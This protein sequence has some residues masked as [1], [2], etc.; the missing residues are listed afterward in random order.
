ML[1]L[2]PK[3]TLQPRASLF[4]LKPTS[5]GM[6][7]QSYTC[8]PLQIAPADPAGL[9]SRKQPCSDSNSLLTSLES[10]LPVQCK[11]CRQRVITQSLS[12]PAAPC[13][14][15]YTKST[16]WPPMTLSMHVPCCAATSSV[17]QHGCR[18]GH[19]QPGQGVHLGWFHVD[20]CATCH[21]QLGKAYL[22]GATYRS[23]V[24]SFPLNWLQVA[25]S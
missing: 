5:G 24:P 21:L 3:T 12:L 16:P 25:S 13:L 9:S 17:K 22:R 2:V 19:P 14:L 6:E 11:A 1:K 10:L 8:Q 18:P 15:C 20:C 23:A 4:W 7:Q